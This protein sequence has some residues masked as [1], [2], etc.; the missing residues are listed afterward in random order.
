MTKTKEEEKP[1]PLDEIEE[2]AVGIDDLLDE[3]VS[4]EDFD[5]KNDIKNLPYSLK[6]SDDDASGIDDDE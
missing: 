1:L 5:E 6:I 2:E 3:D 4:E